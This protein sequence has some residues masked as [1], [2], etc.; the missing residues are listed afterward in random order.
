MNADALM[1]RIVHNAFKIF[2]DNVNMRAE[3]SPIKKAT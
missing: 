3:T 1:D 2:T